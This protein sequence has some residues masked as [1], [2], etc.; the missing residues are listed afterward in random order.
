M[1]QYTQ[2]AMD[3]KRGLLYFML[4]LQVLLGLM[5]I[6]LYMGIPV[7]IGVIG[8]V[9]G[10]YFLIKCVLYR[11]TY[12]IDESGIQAQFSP[13]QKLT[14]LKTK[15][16]TYPWSDIEW[17]MADSDM[18][19]GLQEIQYLKI[20]FSD[21][22]TLKITNNSNSEAI[23]SFNDFKAFFLE[24]VANTKHHLIAKVN[25]DNKP[26][27]DIEVLQSIPEKKSLYRRPLGKILS[28]LFFICCLAIPYFLLKFDGSFTNW[29]KYAALILPGTI[30]ML[31]R[32]F[33][34]K[35]N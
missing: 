21:G 28:L 16:F 26:L 32:S 13:Y 31:Y 9:A 5:A 25:S 10:V 3:P 22:V 24:K 18:S 27:Q 34:K 20:R 1:L 7:W 23:G 11:C 19:R 4:L 29:L 6:I 17:Y 14:V 2:N 30:Y 8:M 12:T 35:S 15:Q 33:R